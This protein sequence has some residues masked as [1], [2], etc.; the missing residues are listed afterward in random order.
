MVELI[1]VLRWI[2]E[3]AAI[4]W[5]GEVF[6]VTHIIAP[7]LHRL[8][9]SP[10]GLVMLKLYPRIFRMATV[11][12]ST[13]ITAG[14]IVA[15]LEARFDYSYFLTTFRG[16]LILVGGLIGLFMFLLHSTVERVEMKALRRVRVEPQGELP[17]ELK[18]LDRRLRVLPRIG[19]T[20]LTIVLVLMIY[21]SHGI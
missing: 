11:S 8:P 21:V 20:L 6:V 7:T 12:S 10:K 5:F 13:T 15:L 3:L 19:F 18:V 4:T 16:Q 1:S 17:Q 2:H 9:D 14:A